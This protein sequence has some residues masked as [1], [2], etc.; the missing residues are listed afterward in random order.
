MKQKIINCVIK[1]NPCE[2]KEGKIKDQLPEVFVAFEDGK[3]EKLFCY[4][5]DNF[6]FN[7]EEF[8]GL[9]KKE[10]YILRGKRENLYLIS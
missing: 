9:T 6:V 10:A 7:K 8:V 5:P 1:P 3:N 4:N 2:V